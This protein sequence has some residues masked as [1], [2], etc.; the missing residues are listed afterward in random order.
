MRCLFMAISCNP[1]KNQV[2]RAAHLSSRHAETFG[3]AP[4]MREH[5]EA[6]LGRQKSALELGAQL[7]QGRT[8]VATSAATHQH[9]HLAASAL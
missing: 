6:F 9:Q 1:S 7:G 4:P 3:K 5:A 8:L 2:E